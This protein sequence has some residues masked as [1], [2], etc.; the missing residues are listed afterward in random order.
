VRERS[1]A[2]GPPQAEPKGPSAMSASQPHRSDH[3]KLGD[4]PASDGT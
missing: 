1:S 2:T 4:E 3:F